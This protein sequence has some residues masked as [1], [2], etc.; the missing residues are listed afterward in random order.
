MVLQGDVVFLR[1]MSKVVQKIELHVPG[2]EVQEPGVGHVAD[3]SSARHARCQL[4]VMSVCNWDL[5]AIFYV[6]F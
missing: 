3:A 4:C 6:L 5:H 1:D 2:L